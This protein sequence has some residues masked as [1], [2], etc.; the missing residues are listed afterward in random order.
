MSPEYAIDGYFSMKSD[1]FSFGVILLEIVSGKKNRGFFHPDHQLNLLGHV[2]ILKLLQ[3]KCSV[4]IC[5]VW[6]LIRK[7]WWD[8]QAW[9]LWEEGNALELMDERLNK[10]GFQNSEAQRCIQVGLLCVQ[11]NPDERPAMWSVLSM[12]ESE[13]MELL[14]VPKQPGFYTER[15][16]SKTHNLPGESSCSTNEVTVTLLYGR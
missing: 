15:T 14:C 12:L 10:D 13:N 16:I 1:I 5:Q 7:L 2:S 11:E 9:K 6:K 4:K 3:A 8:H